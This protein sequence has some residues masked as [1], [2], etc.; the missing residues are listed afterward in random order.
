VTGF[1]EALDRALDRAKDRAKD[2]GKA[3]PLWKAWQERAV[4]EEGTSPQ[5]R[6]FGCFWLSQILKNPVPA[7]SKATLRWYIALAPKGTWLGVVFSGSLRTEAAPW[8]LAKA[9]SD[10]GFSARLATV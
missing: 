1:F 3:R 2:R 4:R 5:K 9:V 7:L 10:I 8:A 6:R